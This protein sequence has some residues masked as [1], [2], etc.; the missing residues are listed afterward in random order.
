MC[1]DKNT[2]VEDAA[3]LREKLEAHGS[4]FRA[5]NAD[6]YADLMICAAA[7]IDAAV[8]LLALAKC[9]GSNCDGKGTVTRE[10]Q[11]EIGEQDGH[12]IYE[13]E[14]VPEPCSWCNTVDY[15]IELNKKPFNA[16]FSTTG[17][18]RQLIHDGE[19]PEYPF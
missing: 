19:M 4:A 1:A 9:P 13:V 8:G 11:R 3:T 18:D 12:P 15:F 7:E 16:T 6:V 10:R 17:H 5:L 2:E 14:A